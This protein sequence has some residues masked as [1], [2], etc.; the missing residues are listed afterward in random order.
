MEIVRVM[1][2]KLCFVTLDYEAALKQS[3][4][5]STFEKDYE[6]PDGNLISIGSERF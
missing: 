4:E 6:L 3:Q 2:E 5:I 1:K